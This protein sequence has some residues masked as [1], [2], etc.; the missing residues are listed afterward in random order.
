LALTISLKRTATNPLRIADGESV[1]FDASGLQFNAVRDPERGPWPLAK[2]SNKLA[3]AIRTRG[4]ATPLSR[5]VH[6]KKNGR[7]RMRKEWG[8]SSLLTQSDALLA[9][10]IG[11]VRS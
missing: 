11:N 1:V 9:K 8:Q 2:S 6:V 7:M 4:K 10:K 3:T 5:L